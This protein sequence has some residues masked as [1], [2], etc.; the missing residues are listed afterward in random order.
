MLCTWPLVLLFKQECRTVGWDDGSPHTR[1]SEQHL[2]TSAVD[3]IEST[4]ESSASSHWHRSQ[5]WHFQHSFLITIDGHER[6]AVN[7]VRDDLLLVVAA[8]SRIPQHRSIRARMIY[9]LL[10]TR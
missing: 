10:S 6:S 4:D 2:D 1:L 9:N 3:S 5:D 8:L 7:T